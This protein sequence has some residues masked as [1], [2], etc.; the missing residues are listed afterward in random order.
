MN[1]VAVEERAANEGFFKSVVPCDE[2]EKKVLKIAKE[3]R[4]VLHRYVADQCH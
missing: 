4:L 1:T 3:L 2:E